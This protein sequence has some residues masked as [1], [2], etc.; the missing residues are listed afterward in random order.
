MLNKTGISAFSTK[1]DVSGLSTGIYVLRFRTKEN[2][3]ISSKLI[4]R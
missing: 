2:Q 1:L 3:T 4:V